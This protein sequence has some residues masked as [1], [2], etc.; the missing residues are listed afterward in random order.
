MEFDHVNG[1]KKHSISNL[2]RGDFA[3]STLLDE[4][5]KVRLICVVCHRLATAARRRGARA[6]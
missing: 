3:L 1:V 4:L 5:K 2:R 6:I